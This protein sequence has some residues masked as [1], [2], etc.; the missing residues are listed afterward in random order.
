MTDDEI[1]IAVER[2]IT[3]LTSEE[4]RAEL[5]RQSEESEVFF[6]WLRKASK[7]TWE[8]LHRPFDI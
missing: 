5:K 1:K 7:P 3:Y 2:A 8:S 6:K 4:G